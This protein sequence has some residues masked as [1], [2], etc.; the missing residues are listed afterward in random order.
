MYMVVVVVVDE[1]QYIGLE[2]NIFLG[3]PLGLGY[4]VCSSLTTKVCLDERLGLWAKPD[5]RPIT[6]PRCTQILFAIC[7]PPSHLM[8]F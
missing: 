6:N 3:G 2:F 5:T 1:S 8:M 7:I 4:L